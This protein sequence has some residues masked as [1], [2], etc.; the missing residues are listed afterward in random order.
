MILFISFPELNEICFLIILYLETKMTKEEHI[1]YWIDSADHDNNVAGNLYNSGNYDWCLFISHLVLEKTLKAFFVY[2]NN[3]RIPPKIHNLVKLAEMSSLELSD[4]YLSF[5]DDMN[6]FNIEVRYP[7]YKNEFY[8][9]C[10]REFS[11]KYFTKMKEVKKWL[12]S[13]IT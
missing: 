11:E 5:L 9:L 7:E 8:K 2:V 1:K 4:E 12:E 6:E 10:T 3:N 13:Q